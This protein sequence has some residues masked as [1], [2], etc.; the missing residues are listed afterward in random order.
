MNDLSIRI[1]QALVQIIQDQQANLE[2]NDPS[3]LRL[4]EIG[5]KSEDFA[6]LALT[7]LICP[8]DPDDPDG[9]CD[10]EITEPGR[11][12]NAYSDKRLVELS[13]GQN[14][15]LRFTIFF[16]LFYN[17]LG[18]D[19]QT[20][21]EASRTMFS[22]IHRAIFEAGLYHGDGRGYFGPLR[23]SDDYGCH[24]VRAMNAVKRRR[25]T[26]AGSSEESFYRGKMWLQFEA[27]ME[28]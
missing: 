9:W 8:N 14:Y 3:R 17:E 20:A 13:G 19:R 15:N 27:Y 7:C 1:M 18:I 16:T 23:R 28:G 6:D 26:P 5:P 25:L 2:P 12:F 22:R 11:N 4:V 24:L 21:F 10:E